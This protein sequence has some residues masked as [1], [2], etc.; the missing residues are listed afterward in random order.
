MVPWASVNA[1]SFFATKGSSF[2]CPASPTH[3]VYGGA[4]NAFDVPAFETFYQN[5]NSMIQSEELAGT[6][7]FIELFPKQA[8]E[9]VSDDATV[10]PWRISQRICKIP[11]HH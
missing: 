3:N 11:Q 8:V 5:Y 7:Y 9:K 1:A 4:V 2:L 10:Y 6:V